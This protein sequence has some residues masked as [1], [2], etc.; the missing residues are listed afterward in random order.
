MPTDQLEGYD[1][2]SP[3]LA[4]LN[5]SAQS[6]DMSTNTMPGFSFADLEGKDAAQQVR[7][8]LRLLIQILSWNKGAHGSV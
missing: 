1:V 4:T 7:S 8:L 6:N 2:V 5:D 3:P